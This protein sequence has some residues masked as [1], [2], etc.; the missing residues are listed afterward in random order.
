MDDQLIITYDFRLSDGNTKR[1]TLSFEAL[2]LDI[3]TETQ[4]DPPSWAYLDYHK[5]SLCSLESSKA[6]YCP[7]AQHLAAILDEFRD[8]FAHETAFVTVISAERTYSRDTTIQQGLSALI[9]I[10]MATSGCPILDHLRPLVRFHLPFANLTET[11]FRM[12]SLYFLAQYFM[13]EA[14]KAVE[15]DLSSIQGTYEQIGQVNRDFAERIADRANKDAN[16]NALV[17]LDCFASMVPLALHDTLEGLK[18]SFSVY[19]K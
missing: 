19:L 10:V 15:W 18:S 16:L 14:G 13:K 2:T 7:P 1:F 12:T 6:P 5:C 8:L 3:Q 17:N 9:G 4:T 11:V